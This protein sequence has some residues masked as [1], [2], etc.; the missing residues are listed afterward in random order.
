MIS[1]ISKTEKGWKK[2]LLTG[3]YQRTAQRLGSWDNVQT[4][5][6]FQNDNNLVLQ[7]GSKTK[8]YHA[9]LNSPNSKSNNFTTVQMFEVSMILKEVSYAHQGYI[10]LIKIQ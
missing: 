6:S 4:T 2:R 1:C 7:G 9:K 5:K 3:P 10:Y 8:I